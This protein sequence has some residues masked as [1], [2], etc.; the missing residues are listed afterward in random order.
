[1]T[2]YENTFDGARVLVTGGLG[3]IHATA[4]D[5]ID[6]NESGGDWLG[7]QIGGGAIGS[8]SPSTTIAG[9]DHAIGDSSRTSHCTSHTVSSSCS[10]ASS[11]SATS[12]GWWSPLTARCVENDHSNVSCP[13]PGRNIR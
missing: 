6:L 7:L 3:L 9:N 12:R 5:F 13:R 1:M 2:N 10:A 4:D 11:C 8:S